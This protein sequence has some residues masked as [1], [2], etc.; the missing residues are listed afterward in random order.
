MYVMV[1][2]PLLGALYVGL[3]AGA[4]K[5]WA[6]AAV[7]STFATLAA[8]GS[9][10]SGLLSGEHPSLAVSGL[11][12]PGGLNLR[13][14]GLGLALALVS[15]LVWFCAGLSAV[16]YLRSDGEQRRYHL[17]YL[18]TLTGVVG[19]F[20]AADFLTLVFFFEIMTLASYVLV[21]HTRTAESV[22]AGNLYLYLSLAGSLVLVLGA[23]MLDSAAG[24][25]TLTA[26]L[27][28]GSVA[29]WAAGL[30]ALGFSVKAGMIPLHLWLP[31]AHP[32]APAPASAV[33]SG[34]MIKTGAYGVL[35]SL[36]TAGE[37]E[38]GQSLGLALIIMASV[39]MLLGVM[40]ALMQSN[41]KRM[42]AYHSISQMGYIL[43]GV[44]V[45]I[46]AGHHDP[47]GAAG[48]LYHM[49]NHA[50]FKSAL[51]LV[52][53]AVY[54]R[55]HELNMYRLGGLWRKMPLTALFGFVAALGIA[56]VPGL[57]GYVSKTVLHHA[58][59]HA[60][61]DAY[62]LRYVEWAFIL[63]GAGTACSFIKFF[64]Y[65]FLGRPKSD[66]HVEKRTLVATGVGLAILAVM[67]VTLGAWPGLFLHN[68]AEPAVVA[69]GEH[70]RADVFVWADLMGIGKCL[71]L[72]AIIFALGT[73][74]GWF[75]AHPPVWLSVGWLAG[76]VM[77]VISGAWYGALAGAARWIGWCELEVARLFSVLAGS[78]KEL[79]CQVPVLRQRP[80]VSVA[81][82]SFDAA[83]I[84]TVLA[85]IL[86]SQVAAAAAAA[87]AAAMA[88]MLW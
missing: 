68:V 12:L 13:A 87:M 16:D 81:D 30:M 35:R 7:V 21:I 9:L 29:Y 14:D 49:V 66:Y 45:A 25:V 69:H 53:G 50:L 27:P 1:V 23:A 71:G 47:M 84:I 88:A 67:I 46:F 37:G 5:T 32:V 10:F 19:T 43:M 78:M 86:L 2:A 77:K 42:L 38:I 40:M 39:T 31:E 59:T 79:D 48:A 17:C 80:P 85:L 76:W 70:L 36:M 18:L 55:T 44:G 24:S 82:L 64:G 41:A 74:F 11:G 58:L 3:A 22:S 33:L 54:M 61:H 6:W 51:F 57:N 4:R 73:R 8:G 15:A 26:H 28:E 62:V 72:G 56:G 52:V 63:T 20:L 34:I 83:V 65:I 75:H 60:A